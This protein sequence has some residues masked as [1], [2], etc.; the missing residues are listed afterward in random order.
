M[1][2]GKFEVDLDIPSSIGHVIL[3][4]F[5]MII[6]L[7]LAAFLYPYALSKFVLN[8]T[9]I[10]TDGKR[11]KRLKVE[12]DLASQIGHVVI[13]VLLTIVTLGLAYFIFLYQ[14]GKFILNKTEVVDL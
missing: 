3:W 10:V 4:Y 12:L 11:I 5:L 6:T 9:Y 1:K 2:F 7:G 13:W 14:I 8:R